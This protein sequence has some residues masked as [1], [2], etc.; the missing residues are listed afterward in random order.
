MGSAGE[1]QRGGP[2]GDP[3]AAGDHHRRDAKPEERAWSC[4]F[5]AH[6]PL[7]AWRQSWKVALLVASVSLFVVALKLMQSG[8]QAIA[9]VV[10]E[11]L[12]VETPIGALG[13][14]W[15]GAYL[16]LSG[17]PVAATAI[18]FFDAR[19][20]DA[21]AAFAM[22]TG[23]RLGAAF[24]VLLLGFLY[25]L[26]RRGSVRD[27]RIGLLALIVT[28]SI[29]VPAFALGYA[30]LELDLLGAVGD[31]SNTLGEALED[32]PVERVKEKAEEVLPPWGVFLAGLALI[33]T[34]FKLFDLS[35]PR[36]D[37]ERGKAS[38]IRRYVYRRWPMFGLG[39]VLTLISLS[40]SVSLGLLVPLHDR[41][42]VDARHVVPY[43][44]G[45][46]IT[47]FIDTMVAAMTMERSGAV[48]IVLLEMGV[49]AIIS[50]S[51]LILTYERYQQA[52]LAAVD[53]L[54]ASPGRLMAFVTALIVLPVALLLSSILG[55]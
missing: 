45:A 47:T 51:I 33:M 43:I 15:G 10:R 26:Y 28:G 41:R 3:H 12:S 14:G 44:M 19:E 16:L 52:M 8:A 55:N 4:A 20:I 25:V 23:S 39:A 11:H 2:E 30:A 27:L 34:S 48:T 38:Q 31:G 46:N 24:I 54:S 36:L 49:V 53:H 21:T 18:T 17:S 6:W 13:F 5:P 1:G 42:I 9:P 7:P 40:V 35:L 50:L 29:Y 32:G 37:A 22:I